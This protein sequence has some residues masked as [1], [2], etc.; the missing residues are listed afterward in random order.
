M[1]DFYELEFNIKDLKS[2]D[3][4]LDQ[5]LSIEYLQGENQY[6]CQRLR[7]WLVMICTFGSPLSGFVSGLI[8]STLR[9]SPSLPSP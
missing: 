1:E 9:E 5:Y 7:F 2:L 4:S 3:E 8:L 6:Y